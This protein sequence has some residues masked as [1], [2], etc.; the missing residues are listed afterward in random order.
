MVA[1]LLTMSTGSSTRLHDDDVLDRWACDARAASTLGLSSDGAPRRK[2]PSAVITT[3]HSASLM[4]SMSESGLNPPNTTECGA[5]MR[6]QA[7]IATG[8]SGIIGM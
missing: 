5:P 2:P 3:L 8:S 4:R 1:A 7:S 6:A